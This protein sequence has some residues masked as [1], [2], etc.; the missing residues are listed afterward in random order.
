LR[1]CTPAVVASR[2]SLRSILILAL[3]HACCHCRTPTD[4]VLR[5]L[6]SLL[7]PFEVLPYLLCRLSRQLFLPLWPPLAQTFVQLLSSK[8][9]Q[10]GQ[11]GILRNDDTLPLRAYG[12]IATLILPQGLYHLLH[13]RPTTI[14][15]RPRRSGKLNLNT[16]SQLE[17]QLVTSA[18]RSC[19]LLQ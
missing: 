4:V 14:R 13:S 6:R 12:S 1:C 11:L 3:R 16:M 8:V 9:L 15:Q 2:L 7:I 10:I 19:A 18:L 17:G 5:P